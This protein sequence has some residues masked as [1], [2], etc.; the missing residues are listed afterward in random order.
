MRL[1]AKSFAAL[2]TTVL[3]AI[4]F[5]S[6]A[7]DSAASWPSK[8]VRIIVPFPAGGTAD[9]LPRFVSERLTA[10]WGQPFLVENR[11][12]AAG[13][14]G[15]EAVF[16][17]E[18]DG[19]TLL[20]APP[21]PLVINPSLYAKLAFDPT[22]FV[23]ISVLAEVPNV[24]LLHPKI[25]AN[26]VREAIAYAKAN[27]GKLNY[28]SQGSGSTSHLTAELFKS[29]GG[30]LTITHVPYKGTAPAL[31]DL[32]GGQVEIM[33]DNL[34]VSLQHVRSGKLKALAVAS[35]KRVAALPDVPTMAEILPGFVSVAWYGVVAPPK[36]SPAIAEKLSAAIAESLKTPEMRKRL[37]ELSAEAVGN[38]PAE[39]SAYMRQDAERWR[40]VI[41]TANV[42]AD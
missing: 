12:G 36:T 7:Q 37:V 35:Q 24:F 34:G 2:V 4:A 30:G 20:S 17:A 31:T 25:P 14:I 40:N 32:L 15:A 5:P 1:S 42:K 23:T 38:T 16:K 27:P 28:A 11:A 6:H 29:M 22:Q 21:P 19:Y 39:M 3:S 10:K 33:F 26:S 9:V 13:N 18:P 8:P 41:R